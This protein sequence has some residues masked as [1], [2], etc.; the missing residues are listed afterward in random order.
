MKHFFEVSFKEK[1]NQG[2]VDSP[3]KHEYRYQIF[4]IG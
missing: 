4:N 1:V 2:E 3:D